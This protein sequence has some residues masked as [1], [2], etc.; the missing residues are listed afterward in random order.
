MSMGEA[1]FCLLR[2]AGFGSGE[3]FFVFAILR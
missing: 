2:V 1:R 3:L